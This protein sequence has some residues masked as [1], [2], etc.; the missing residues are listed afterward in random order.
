[1]RT[2]YNRGQRVFKTAKLELDIANEHFTA[3]NPTE[4]SWNRPGFALAP[5]IFA[6]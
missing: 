5:L 3:G 4:I 2:P 1:M 6:Q